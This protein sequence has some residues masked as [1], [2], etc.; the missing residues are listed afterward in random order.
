MAE[1][2]RIVLRTLALAR[3][4]SGDGHI[5]GGGL[6]I[7]RGVLREGVVCNMKVRMK[8]ILSDPA[9]AP[10]CVLGGYAVV[11][12][13]SKLLCVDTSSSSKRGHVVAQY[14]HDIHDPRIKVY[15]S[16]L[17][18]PCIPF[19]QLFGWASDNTV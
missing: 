2:K 8:H 9:F 1:A 10:I 4:W 11:R 14:A 18:S 3:R 15:Y 16:P 13:Q 5:D 12:A 17:S 19:F 6:G 7:Q